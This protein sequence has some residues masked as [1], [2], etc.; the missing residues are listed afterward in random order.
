MTEATPNALPAAGPAVRRSLRPLILLGIV[1]VAGFLG[2]KFWP[3]Q[4]GKAASIQAS[5]SIEAREILLSAQV[6]GRIVH[7]AVDEGSAMTAGQIVAQLDT[8]AL[9]TQV[10]QARAALSRAE[11]QWMEA[12]NGARPE[13][14]AQARAQWAA[15]N[16]SA[17]GALSA[18]VNA[19][20]DLSRV[21]ALKTQVD[22]AESRYAQSIAA[23]RQAQAALRLTEEGTREQQIAQAQAAVQQAT[24][25][26][27]H[28]Q[29]D[30]RRALALY[31][32]DAVSRQDWESAKA[33]R[34]TARSQVSQAQAHLADLR[35]GAR[36]PEVRGAEMAVAQAQA[37]QSG[38]LQALKD[39][40]QEYS[41]RLDYKARYDAA[42]AS[43]QAALN[44][45][46]AALAALQLLTAGTRPEEI[47]AARDAVRQAR[48]N[49][50]YAKVQE[51]YATVRASANG[52]INTKIAE[53]GEVVAPGAPIV[54]LY[55]LDHPWLRIYVPENQYGKL[56]IGQPVEVTV[57]SFPGDRF[58]GIVSEI[59]SDAEF[60]PKSVQTA[61]ERVQLVYGVKVELENKQHLLKPGMPADAT[62]DVSGARPR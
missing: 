26:L 53:E 6:G 30:Y 57:D 9:G 29:S 56:T 28:D 46:S 62:I 13:Q 1:L 38:S 61:E 7:L 34:D 47:A 5:G 8:S 50:N 36:P 45:R 2:W 58:H 40:R 60:T 39:A 25:A 52:V 27:A 31:Q 11:Q 41:D 21:T 10:Q 43:Y 16:A 48:A 20:M 42:R 3:R 24:V 12:R 33:V 23:T 14:I 17:A 54:S 49:L 19:R 22:A 44:Q 59:S 35:A 37:S 4:P 32:Q 55:D 51:G 18:L 15:A